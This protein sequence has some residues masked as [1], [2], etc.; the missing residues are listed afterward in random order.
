[1]DNIVKLLR[2]EPLEANS[3]D[4]SGRPAINRYNNIQ[5][6]VSITG[7][8]G[9]TLLVGLQLVVWPLPGQPYRRHALDTMIGITL[10]KMTVV[11]APTVV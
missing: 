5:L 6:E 3:G 10:I 2:S 4:V 9:D 8:A 1:V 11:Q 7:A